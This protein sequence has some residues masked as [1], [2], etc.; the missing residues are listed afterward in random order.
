MP[1]SMYHA[2]VPVFLQLLGGLKGVVDWFPL[3]QVVGALNILGQKRTEKIALLYQVT[4]MSDILRGQASASATAT[5]QRIKAR[6]ASTR[7]QRA[8]SEFASF[9][10]G[11]QKVRAEIIAKHFDAATIIERSN[12]MRTKDAELAEPAA[13][14]IKSEQAQYRIEV[15]A[16]G[17]RCYALLWPRGTSSQ[18]RWQ[19]LRVR[20]APPRGPLLVTGGCSHLRWNVSPGDDPRQSEHHGGV[21]AREIPLPPR[22][23]EGV[24]VRLRRGVRRG[25]LRA[26]AALGPERAHHRGPHP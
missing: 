13:Q 2:S 6:A 17:L 11:A 4:G 20:F 16:E 10:T 9:A 14:L 8:Q 18:V 26:R 3:D 12:V 23:S 5:E 19:G 24:A 7:T 25:G 15:A 22:P 1:I 21:T